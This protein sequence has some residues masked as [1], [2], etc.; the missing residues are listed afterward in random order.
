MTMTETREFATTA[1][2]GNRQMNGH[3]DDDDADADARRAIRM[4]GGVA[5]MVFGAGLVLSHPAVRR[6]AVMALSGVMPDLEKP[7][8]GGLEALLP[9]IERYM[10]IRS[11]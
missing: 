8:R 7:L 11:M 4:A 5:L 9:D 2:G 10:K 6:M 3:A 1:Q